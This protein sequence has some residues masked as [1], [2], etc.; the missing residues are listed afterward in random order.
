MSKS[1]V[2]YTEW[3]DH[4]D[5]LTTE[6]RGVLLDSIMS[7]QI[8][9][10]LPEMDATTAMCFSFIE[11]QFERDREKYE[12]KSNAG[13]QGGAPKGNS[14]A[15][16]QKQAE[17]NRNKQNKPDVYVNDDVNVN[18]ISSA[19]AR[20]REN[21]LEM[22]DRLIAG[23]ALS[24]K[25]VDA[26]REWINYKQERKEP[27][28][29][30]GMNSLISQAVN[31]G[32]AY[33]GDVVCNAIRSSMASNYKGIAWPKDAKRKNR[34]PERDYKMDDLELKLLATN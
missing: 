5:R 13:K 2:M 21:Q 30:T 27:Y 31:L 23:R 10:E 19:R 16:K 14:N 32:A 1:F 15:K 6:Q 12:K 29:E 28:K 8:G 18:N 33:G 7:Y 26:L 22:F 3:T 17:T 4:V 25:M 20:A 34:P 11:K 9:R 24:Q